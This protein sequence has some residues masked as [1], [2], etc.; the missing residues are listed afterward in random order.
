MVTDNLRTSNI[1]TTDKEKE[2]KKPKDRKETKKSKVMSIV[3]IVCSIFFV[4]LLLIGSCVIFHNVYF[5]SFW[6]NGQSMYPTLNMNALDANGNLKG[7]NPKNP[8]SESGARVDYGIMDTNAFTIDNLQRFN[9][10]VTKFSDY[11]SSNYVKRIIAL[12]G[13]SYSFTKTGDLYIN[14]EYV[15]QPIGEEYIK[16]TYMAHKTEHMSGTLKED[17]YF[18][19]GDNRGHSDDSRSH[20]PIKKRYIIGKA[21]AIEGM[22]TLEKKYNTQTSLYEWNCINISY[23]WPK[24]L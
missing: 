15:E 5:K 4:I 6:V 16:E 22:C 24:F 21:V 13:E 14:G 8:S 9:I 3:T 11:D 20:G 17:E 19:C 2:G 23:H 12:P 7:K 1:N 10:I 18:V